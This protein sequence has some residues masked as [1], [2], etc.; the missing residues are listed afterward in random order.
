MGSGT[1]V[2]TVVF[3]R[4]RKGDLC[5]RIDGKIAFPARGQPQ[6]GEG[7]EWE[8]EIVGTNPAGSVFF[9][10]LVRR[11]ATRAERVRQDHQARMRARDIQRA[12]ARDLQADGEALLQ[13]LAATPRRVVSLGVKESGVVP[14]R[15]GEVTASYGPDVADIRAEPDGLAVVIE[16]Q[17]IIVR[18]L[19]VFHGFPQGGQSVG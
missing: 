17:L 1:T 2:T 6:P 19:D 15:G 9:L 8:V 11:V 7:D 4:G 10:R 16:R 3:E 12:V 14:W 13:A 5:A 18:G